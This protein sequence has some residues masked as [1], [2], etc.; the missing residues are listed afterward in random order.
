[1]NPQPSTYAEQPSPSPQLVVLGAHAL[2]VVTLLVPLSACG[3]N[4]AAPPGPTSASVTVDGHT[5]NISGAVECTNSSANPRATPPETGSGTTRISAH[6]DSA[7]FN[8]ALSNDSPPRL[9][10]FALSLTVDNGEYE[11]PYQSALS[12]NQITVTRQGNTYLVKGTGASV[13]RVPPGRSTNPTFEI[14]VA[15]P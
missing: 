13:T 1:M 6:D 14:D 3:K 9:D 11:M 2:V 4:N 7:G 5:H 12:S 10:G 8:L 15:C